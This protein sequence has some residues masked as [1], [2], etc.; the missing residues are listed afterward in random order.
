MCA[1]WEQRIGQSVR[2]MEFD[3]DDPMLLWREDVLAE[4]RLLYDNITSDVDTHP[5][6]REVHFDGSGDPA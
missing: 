2:S 4:P 5:R 6:V 3:L 1:A